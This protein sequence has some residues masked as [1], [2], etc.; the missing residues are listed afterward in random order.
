MLRIDLSVPDEEYEQARKLGAHWDAVE[1]IWYI[2]NSIDPTPFINW[3]P[4]YNVH[5]EYWYLAQTQTACPHCQENTTV[6]ACMLPAGH[7]L[8]EADSDDEPNTEIDYTEQD[9]PAFLFY[10]ADLPTLMR[11]VLPGFH[12]RLRKVVS[13]PLQRQHW[14]NHCEH[15]DAPLDDTELFTE[16]GGAFFP[17]SK[18]QAARIQLHRIDQP[19]VGYCEDISHHH[20]HFDP[21]QDNRICKA[22][23]WF[24]WMT[25]VVNAPSKYQH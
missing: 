10:L 7:K 14:I 9:R 19:F 16:I 8:L 25:Q 5:A 24:E 12:H 22:C 1:Q 13:Q 4:F 11:N 15:C 2:D 21:K 6:T 20:Y 3:L 23:D 17:A 18:E